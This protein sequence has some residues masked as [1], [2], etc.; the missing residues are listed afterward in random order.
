PQIKVAPE[1]Q[2]TEIAVRPGLRLFDASRGMDH[3]AAHVEG[4]QWV[5]RARLTADMAEGRILVLGRSASLVSGVMQ[6]LTE[7]GATDIAGH[8][9][10]PEIWTAAGLNVVSTPDSPAEEECIDF[11]FFVHDRHNDNLEAAR[12]YLAWELGLL[13]QLDDQERAALTPPNL[14]EMGDV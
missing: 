12:Q 11:L 4:S 10:G 14:M 8:V 1:L 2:L 13:E 5:T 9:G 3:R 7:L 6:R